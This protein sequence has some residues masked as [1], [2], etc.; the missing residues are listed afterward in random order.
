MIYKHDLLKSGYFYLNFTIL[1]FNDV[2]Q[3]Q[4]SDE[5]LYSK[6]YFQSSIASFLAM[7]LEYEPHYWFLSLEQG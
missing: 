1:I 4:K 2:M 5:P 3:K 6:D 7:Q